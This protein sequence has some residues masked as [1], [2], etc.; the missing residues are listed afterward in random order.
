MAGVLVAL[1]FSTAVRKSA[2]RNVSI[3]SAT[4]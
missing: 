1:R 3:S 4:E 2:V